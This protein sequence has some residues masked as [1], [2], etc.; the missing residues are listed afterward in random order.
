M[1]K[2]IYCSITNQSDKRLIA[3]EIEVARSFFRRLRGLL[4]RDSLQEGEGILLW[5][6]SSIHCIGMHFPIDVIFLDRHSRVISIR[7]YMYPCSTASH[8]K[9][10]CVLELSAG[11]IKKHGI[12]VGDQLLICFNYGKE[13]LEDRSEQ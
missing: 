9:A 13:T 6:C 7:E 11:E 1:S 2:S 3:T 8:K 4:G 5:P 12:K 10:R